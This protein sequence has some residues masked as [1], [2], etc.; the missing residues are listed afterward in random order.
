MKDIIV[1]KYKQKFHLMYM[2]LCRYLA[3]LFIA[4]LTVKWSAGEME[5]LDKTACL[6][7][8]LVPQFWYCWREGVIINDT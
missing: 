4:S 8:V 5:V 2:Q 3:S 1:P 7:L 6:E